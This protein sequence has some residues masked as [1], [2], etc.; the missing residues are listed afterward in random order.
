MPEIPNDDDRLDVIGAT[1]YAGCLTGSD[2]QVAVSLLGVDERPRA[3]MVEICLHIDEGE[4]GAELSQV[5]LFPS[6]ARRIA[7]ALLNAADQ[8][9]GT[10][11]LCFYERPAGDE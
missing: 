2:D 8:L 10:V 5:L 4:E 1:T 11:P 9:D 7:A 3:V 6:D